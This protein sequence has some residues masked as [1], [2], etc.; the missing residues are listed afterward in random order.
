MPRPLRMAWYNFYVISTAPSPVICLSRVASFKAK[1]SHKTMMVSQQKKED[2]RAAGRRQ[3]TR[4]RLNKESTCLSL[5][6]HEDN[7]ALCCRGCTTALY[8]ILG[9]L[10]PP[11]LQRNC[12]LQKRCLRPFEHKHK[13][14]KKPRFSEP[15]VES[16]TIA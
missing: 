3:S 1:L 2:H 13:S 4:L 11:I 12:P 10:T 15:T 16:W 9:K 14:S 7:R 6:L 5:R 8:G